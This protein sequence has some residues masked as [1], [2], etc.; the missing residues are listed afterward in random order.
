MIETG[1]EP[2]TRYGRLL[3][4]TEMNEYMNNAGEIKFL[5]YMRLQKL[6]NTITAAEDTEIDAAKNAEVFA[7]LIQFLDNKSL[8]PLTRDAQDDGRKALR[9]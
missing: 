7:G 6:K 4:L 1:Y 2:R 3:V 5:G 8:A 9:S